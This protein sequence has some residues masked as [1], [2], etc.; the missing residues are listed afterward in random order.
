M[1]IVDELVSLYRQEKWHKIRMSNREASIYY[2]D[3]LERGRI[4]YIPQGDEILGYV[5]F[6]KINLTQLG[7]LVLADTI[8]PDIYDENGTIL[9]VSSLFV[10]PKYRHLGITRKLRKLLIEKNPDC[11]FLTGETQGKHRKSWA[12]YKLKKEG[13]IHG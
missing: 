2:Q 1:N 4:L 3:L 8:S 9:Y 11:D 10:V 13:A 5:Y 12:V 6:S 7:Y